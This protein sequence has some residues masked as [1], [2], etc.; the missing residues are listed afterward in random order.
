MSR[1]EP[2]AYVMVR[3]G[4]C[5]GQVLAQAVH[6]A[7][8]LAVTDPRAAQL[9]LVVVSAPTQ[10][11]FDVARSILELE[12]IKAVEWREPARE[13]ELTAVA[14]VAIKPRATA[15]MPLALRRR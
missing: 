2:K 3:P 15:S 9:P 11:A 12:E 8:L 13:C 14:F 5:S 4:L 1:R 7:M 6:A 10:G